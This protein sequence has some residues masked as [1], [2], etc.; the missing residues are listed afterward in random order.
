MSAG[1]AGT[2]KRT[3]SVSADDSV[4]INQKQLNPQM[5]AMQ[6]KLKFRPMDM[7]LAMQLSKLF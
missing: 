6:G 7:G 1:F 2:P 3:I 4:K 5:A